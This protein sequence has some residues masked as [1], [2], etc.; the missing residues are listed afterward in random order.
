MSLKNKYENGYS[1]LITTEASVN[2]MKQELIELQPQL[3]ETAKQVT[4]STL[5]VQEKTVAAEIVKEAVSKEEAIAQEAADASNAIK[6]DCETE[7]AK[8][9]PALKA[10]E[11]ALNAISKND[12]T[13]MKGNNNP[14]PDVLEVMTAVGILFDRKPEGKMD[15]A[16]GKK[17]YIWWP[18]I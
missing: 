18:T 4:E 17:I 16:S 13:E 7:L 6:V 9:I 10:A 11:K 3:I 1:T 12:I 14:V 8:A 2:I 5:V 15:P